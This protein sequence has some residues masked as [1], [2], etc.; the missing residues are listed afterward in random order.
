MNAVVEIWSDIAC[1]WCW[2]GKRRL[3]QALASHRADGGAAVDVHWRAFELD[4]TAPASVPQPV[5]YVGRLAAKYRTSREGAQ[6]MIDRMTQVGAECGLDFRFDR[7][8][9]TN[10][11]TA[12]RLLFWAGEQSLEAQD[13]LK[14]ALF[15]AYMTEGRS[16]S[17]PDTLTEIATSLG[18]FDADEVQSMLRG[19]AHADDVRAEKKKAARLGVTGV[20]FFVIDQQVALHGAQ[21]PDVLLSALSKARELQASEVADDCGPEGCSV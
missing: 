9:P 2:V 20:P 12:H 17:E 3:E 13:Q 1:P 11:F 7:V 14:E 6:S 15:L 10:T 21:P 18:L 4:P 8:Q 5:D 16:V 19:N